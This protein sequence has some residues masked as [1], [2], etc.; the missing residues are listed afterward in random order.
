MLTP[1]SMCRTVWLKYGY[2]HQI[3]QSLALMQRNAKSTVYNVQGKVYPK[4]GIK[5]VPG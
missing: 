3:E 5:V 4:L 1:L 2:L